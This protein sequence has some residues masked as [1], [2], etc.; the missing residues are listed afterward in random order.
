MLHMGENIKFFRGLR[1]FHQKEVA[2]RL[3]ITQ[4]AYEKIE[5]KE[6]VD[7]ETLAK[8]ALALEFP[9]EVFK[10]EDLNT[11]VNNIFQTYGNYGTIWNNSSGDLDSLIQV[12][13]RLIKSKDEEIATLKKL[14]SKLE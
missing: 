9:V 12:Y 6:L 14:V 1:K 13:E 11:K 4:Q 2:S 5:K 3:S 8:I 10:A 7:D